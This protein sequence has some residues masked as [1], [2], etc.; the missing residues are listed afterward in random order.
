MLILPTLPLEKKKRKKEP[1]MERPSFKE[2]KDKV[3]TKK[4]LSYHPS[5]WAVRIESSR[6]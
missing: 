4:I 2:A 1:R 5:C 3:Y 6:C